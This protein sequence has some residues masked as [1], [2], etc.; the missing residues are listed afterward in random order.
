MQLNYKKKR[1]LKLKARQ[2]Q[3]AKNVLFIHKQGYNWNAPS[4]SKEAEVDILLV[5]RWF[6]EEIVT[7]IKVFGSI[8]SLHVLP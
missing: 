6:G 5:A 8:A 1:A 3:I 4:F 7:Y 2:Y